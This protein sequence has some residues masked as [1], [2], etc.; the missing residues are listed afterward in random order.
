MRDAIRL[1]SDKEQMVL[2]LVY[3]E[4]VTGSE[5]ARLIGVTE[6]RVSQILSGVRRKLKHHMEL[7]DS[8]DSMG[9]AA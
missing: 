4:G 1:L 6:S 3:I 9:I 8:V 5:A 7:Y 2:S